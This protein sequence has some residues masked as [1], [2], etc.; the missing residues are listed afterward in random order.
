MGMHAWLW[1]LSVAAALTSGLAFA[2]A[3]EVLATGVPASA[4]SGVQRVTERKTSAYRDVLAEFDAAIRAAPEDAEIAVARC[5]FISQFT[6][7]EYG[8]WV[9]SAPDDLETCIGTLESRWSKA[10]AAQLFKLDQLWGDEAVE[11]GEKLLA[12]ASRWP[13]PLRRALLTKLSEAQEQQDHSMRAGE[14]AVMAAKLGEPSRAALAVDHLV[15]RK[16]FALAGELL[17]RTPPATESWQAG[18]RVEA[19]LVLPD[20]RA[21]LTELRRYAGAGFD[22]GTTIAARAHLRAGDVAAARTLLQASTG[23][24]EVLQQARFDAALAARDF[25]AAAAL[26]N[27][28]DTANFAANAQRFAV[29]A[30]QA[31]GSLAASTLLV[32]MLAYGAGLILI[33]LLPGTVLVPVHYRGL[34]RQLRGRRAIPLFEGIGLRHAWVGAALMLCVPVL[35]GAVVEP[36]SLATLLGGETPPPGGALFRATTWGTAIALLC[37]V[38]LMRNMGRRAIIGDRA[39]LRAWWRVLIAWACLMVLHFVISLWH[40]QFGGG[41]PTFQTKMVESLTTGGRESYGI[42]VTLLVTAL[43]VPIFEEFVFRGL[44]LGGLTRHISFG[45]AN[46][47]QAL[48]FAAIHGDPPRFLFYLAVG[49]LGGWL[50]KRTGSLAPAI[51]LHGLNNAL[52]ILLRLMA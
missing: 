49:L 39:V 48:L 46:L 50:V 17:R 43:L 16:D 40:G 31:P 20:R 30:T 27:V 24:G 6:D 37:M 32:A 38:P 10:P 36:T 7:E 8:E 12:G 44:I 28:V 26:I 42:A 13:P 45:W 19:A 11:L 52:A 14:L 33:A 41:D 29:V 22:V 15:A 5:K 35:A 4:E 23:K 2:G 3:P 1:R 21:A 34:M 47:L 9:E 25:D 18:A 51:A